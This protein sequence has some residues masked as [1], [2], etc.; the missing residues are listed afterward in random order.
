M[1]LLSNMEA[2]KWEDE[3]G[4]CVAPVAQEVE[5]SSTNHRVSGLIPSLSAVVSLGKTF[6]PPCLQ[7]Q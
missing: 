4:G 6:H 7:C 5:W 3:E 1:C 2:P